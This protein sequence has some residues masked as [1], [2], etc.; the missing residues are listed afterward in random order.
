M[1]LLDEIE[2]AHPDVFNLLLQVM[3]NGTLTDNN[4]R[5]ADFRNVILIMT[6]NV[7]AEQASRVSMGFTEQDHTLDF[8]GELKKVF[9]PEFRNRLDS[10][11]QFNRLSPEVMS[12]VVNKFVYALESSLEDKKVRLSL[13]DEARQWLA[14][15]GYDPLMGARPMARLVQEKIK[16]PLAEMLLFGELQNGGEVVID[17]NEDGIQLQVE[18]LV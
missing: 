5:K 3:D 12:S 9:T 13:T 11:V 2:K 7:G 1:V 16:Q 14:K 6:S 18:E 17:A 4:G 10:V 15:K 8:Q